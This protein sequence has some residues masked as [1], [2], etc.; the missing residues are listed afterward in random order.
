MKRFIPLILLGV[1]VIAYA[2]SYEAGDGGGGSGGVTEGAAT[3]GTQTN[4][5]LYVNSTGKIE[6][7]TSFQFVPGAELDVA[8]PTKIFDAVTINL[9]TLGALNNG[10]NTWGIAFQ[11]GDPLADRAFLRVT[12]TSSGGINKLFTFQNSL[13]TN[14]VTI[15]DTGGGRLGI[16][17]ATPSRALDVV[18]GALFSSSVTAQGPII[19]STNITTGG[20]YVFADGSKQITAAT[21]GGITGSGTSGKVSAWTSSS[22][23]GDATGVYTTGSYFAIRDSVGLC[24]GD[25]ADCSGGTKTMVANAGSSILV[26]QPLTLTASGATLQM[27]NVTGT[28]AS[29]AVTFNNSGI[30]NDNTNASF[31]LDIY[32]SGYKEKF[33]LDA[34]GLVVSTQVNTNA[35]STLQSKGSFSTNIV[36]TAAA[37]TAL[38]TDFTILAD[39]TSGAFTVTLPAAAAIK[40]RIYVIKKIDSSIN[41]VTVDGNASETIDGATTKAI[42]LQYSAAMIQSDGANWRIIAV[43][44]SSITL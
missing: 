17:T 11:D 14:L 9:L 5:V 7:D 44:A 27:A 21:G 38:A 8:T 3:S 34:T 41:A 30:H 4:G 6:T 32:E 35:T 42:T 40:G 10:S 25:N 22:A 28:A 19:G 33:R 24:I 26:Y 37:Y 43:T 12:N 31:G 2:T 16:G 36:S 18:G 13:S 23:I 29:P 39:A 1:A 20:A 15:S